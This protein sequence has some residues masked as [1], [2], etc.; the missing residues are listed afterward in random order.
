VWYPVKARHNRHNLYIVTDTLLFSVYESIAIHM[1]L[2]DSNFLRRAGARVRCG[3]PL[4]ARHNRHNFTSGTDTPFI[5]VY[6]SQSIKILLEGNLPTN[7]KV[8]VKFGGSG[9]VPVKASHD[10]HNLSAGLK[11]ISLFTSMAVL[12]ACQFY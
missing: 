2:G 10:D 5:S 7:L 3:T 4:K 9:V 11:S 8:R 6:A 12:D 1:L